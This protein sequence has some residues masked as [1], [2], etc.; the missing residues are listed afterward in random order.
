ME[1]INDK[2]NRL[3]YR[4]GEKVFFNPKAADIDP[5]AGCYQ[6]TCKNCLVNDLT[7]ELQERYDEVDAI[8]Y[9]RSHGYKVTKILSDENGNPIEDKRL[10]ISWA[11]GVSFPDREGSDFSPCDDCERDCSACCMSL[12]A[13][14]L[15]YQYRKLDELELD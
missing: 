14:E 7:T 6:P 8:V 3:T 10:G 1:E 5:C 11:C 13:A 12:M 9:C 15:D 4:K 2:S